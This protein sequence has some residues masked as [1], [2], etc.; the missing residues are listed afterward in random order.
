MARKTNYNME[1]LVQADVNQQQCMQLHPELI[2]T[3]GLHSFPGHVSASRGQMAA[4]QVGQSVVLV[5]PTVKTIQS[6]TD[7]EFGKYMFN[8][9]MPEDGRILA[10]V[11]RMDQYRGQGSVR[12]N[13][14]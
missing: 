2:H 4:T 8:I 13:P 3:A 7:N 5:T 9:R 10:I 1:E 11:D 14:E 6:G 12:F